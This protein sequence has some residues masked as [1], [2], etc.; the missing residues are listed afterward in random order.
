MKP[1]Y[2]PAMLLLALLSTSCSS[3]KPASPTPAE[4]DLPDPGDRGQTP[5]A[6]PTYEPAAARSVEQARDDLAQ[7]SGMPPDQIVVSSVQAV[8]WP[9]SSLGCPQPGMAYAQVLTPGYLILLEAGGKVYEY[10]AGRNSN[11]FYCADPE[12]PVPGV[13]G[14]V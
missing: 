10:H 4:P 7:R 8:T 11:V 14:D 13:P 1:Y 12:P 9:D 6:G 2:V 5:G 3:M